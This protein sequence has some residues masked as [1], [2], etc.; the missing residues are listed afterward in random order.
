[1]MSEANLLACE[2]VLIRLAPD[3]IRNE[4]VNI[5]VALYE[6]GPGHFAG[7][8]INPDLRRARQISPAFDESDLA[9]LEADLLSRLRATAPAWA[10]RE[11]FLS[12]AQ[13]TFSHSLQLTAPT[14]VLT[15]D[16]AAELDRLY[17][18]YAAAPTLPD[19]PGVEASHRRRILQH[20][21]SV[22]Q[23]ER[24]L[25]HLQRNLRAGTLLGQPDRFRFDFHYRAAVAHHLIQAMPLGGEEG[26]V[27]A[28]CFTVERLRARLPDLDV[29]GFC[30]T[31][32]RRPPGSV[33]SP[34]AAESDQTGDSELYQRNLLLAAGIRI[35]S[36]GEAPAEAARIRTRLGIA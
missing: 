10:S 23:A 24:V 34:A 29:A 2:Y 19:L 13:E 17:Q 5:G 9:G 33:G 25:A 28:L 14:A 26:P 6:P 27:K 7:V 31:E 30:E 36:L 12:L 21:Q 15:V 4:H 11:Y 18:Q 3:P 22:F 35:L 1:M 32:A 20:L 16:P 8:R